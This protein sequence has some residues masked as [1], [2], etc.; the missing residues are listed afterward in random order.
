MLVVIIT[1]VVLVILQGVTGVVSGDPRYSVTH[2]WVAGL[3]CIISAAAVYFLGRYLNGRK[4][5]M[6]IDKSTGREIEL[7]KRHDFFF[8][9]MEYW[10]VP[11]VVGGVVLM[12]SK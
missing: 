4:G 1:V 12:F 3:A 7:K 10:A 6:V 9:L 2:N 11:L 8:I 5:Q